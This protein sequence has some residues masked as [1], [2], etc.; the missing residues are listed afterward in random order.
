MLQWPAGLPTVQVLQQQPGPAPPM[1]PPPRHLLAQHPGGP[2]PPSQP[3]PVHLLAQ[4]P[5]PRAAGPPTPGCQTK[6]SPAAGVSS[7]MGPCTVVPPGGDPALGAWAP[8]L[9][10]APGPDAQPGLPGQFVKA[11]PPQ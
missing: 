10:P 3:P 1:Q 8:R 2:Q 4:P 5:A 9:D 6:A 11:R 7:P